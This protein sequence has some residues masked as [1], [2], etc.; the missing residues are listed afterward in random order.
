MVSLAGPAVLVATVAQAVL[1]V[2]MAALD[3]LYLE[4]E[5][6]ARLSGFVVRLAKLVW[7]F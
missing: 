2:E 3:A 7:A 1:G 6:E 5:V 4:G